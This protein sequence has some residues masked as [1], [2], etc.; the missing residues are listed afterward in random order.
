MALKIVFSMFNL[1][2]MRAEQV[3]EMGLQLT[4]W[5]MMLQPVLLA[6]M[7]LAHSLQNG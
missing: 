5:M 6:K 3:E 2:R 4:H 1:L 7:L